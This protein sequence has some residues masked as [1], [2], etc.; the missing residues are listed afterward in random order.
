MKCEFREWISSLQYVAIKADADCFNIGNVDISKT[1][2][3][4]LITCIC[5]Y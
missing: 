2:L 3:P 1:K 5:V 4:I